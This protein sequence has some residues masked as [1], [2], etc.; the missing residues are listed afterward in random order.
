MSASA[1]SK[2][3]G[4]S[5]VPH[6]IA[7]EMR[8]R[9]QRGPGPAALVRL[10]VKGDALPGKFND[11]TP[12]DLIASGDWAWHDTATAIKGTS[13]T[14]S[15]WTFNGKSAAWGPGNSFTVDAD[16]M[17]KTSI[18][19]EQ[20]KAWISAATY[21]GPAGAIHPD[22]VVVHVRNDQK[23]NLKVTGLRVWTSAKSAP[24]QVLHAGSW[25]PVAVTIGAS[26]SGVIEKQIPNLPLSYAAV[27]LRTAAGSLWAYSRVKAEHFAISAGW[28]NN[29]GS[30]AHKDPAFLSLLKSLHVDTAHYQ[31]LPGYSDNPA[32]FAKYPLKRFNKLDPIDVYSKAEKLI[33]VHAVEFLGEPQYGGGKPVPPQEIYDKLLPYRPSPLPTSVTHSEERIWRWYAGLSDFPHYDAYRV[34]APAADAWMLYDRWGGKKIRWGA[35]LETIGVMCRSLRELNQPMPCA[36]WSQGP[37]EGWDDPFDGRKR[38]SPTPAELRSQAIHALGARITSLYWFNLSLNSLMMFPDTWDAMLRVGREIRMLE[39]ILLD[40]DHTAFRKQSLLGTRPDW[41]LSVVSSAD[42]ALCVAADL[43]YKIS[44]PAQE[45]VFGK[46]RAVRFAFPL[47]VRLR[48]PLDVFRVDADGV[49]NV[50]WQS[51]GDGIVIDDVRSEDALYVVGQSKAVRVGVQNRHAAALA[52]EKSYPVDRVALDVLWKRESEKRKKKR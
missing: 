32:L 12:S 16:G 40:G 41:D 36:Y 30:D 23:T 28:I 38:R 24:W 9:Q 43:A 22:R 2:I 10:F 11:K 52:Y 37:H 3:I 33:D 1:Q 25:L 19:I 26:D 17:D 42:A 49:H 21:R 39:P 47:P 8:Y 46:P 6:T 34:T 15:V 48:K 5:I 7:P 13:D 14:L 45:F 51:K 27:E 29:E 35:P 44:E 50:K 18:R 20:P 31:E 4:V